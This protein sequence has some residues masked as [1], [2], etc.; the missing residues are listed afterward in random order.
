MYKDNMV[1]SFTYKGHYFRESGCTFIDETDTYPNSLYVST[2]VS[3]FTCVA[4]GA[5]CIKLRGKVEK[6]K[7]GRCANELEGKLCSLLM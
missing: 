2:L 7:S 1:L 6:L 3:K 5:R 4:C